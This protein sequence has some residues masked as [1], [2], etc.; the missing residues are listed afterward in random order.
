MHSTTLIQIYAAEISESW[1]KQVFTD[2]AKVCKV[3][4]KLEVWSALYYGNIA[5]A[6]V[7]R[8]AWRGRLLRSG[9]FLSCYEAFPGNLP[10]V[11][12][13]PRFIP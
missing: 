3:G 9:N 12:Y 11:T 5:M 2:F 4:G 7:W 1:I 13:Y 6:G 10:W 8:M